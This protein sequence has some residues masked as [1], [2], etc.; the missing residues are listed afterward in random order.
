MDYFEEHWPV[1]CG[2]YTLTLAAF[3]YFR[4][5]DLK[6]FSQ[7]KSRYLEKDGTSPQIFL[8]EQ[9]LN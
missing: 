5:E 2:S 7:N 3:Q 1:F 6:I 8:R 9:T 4:K